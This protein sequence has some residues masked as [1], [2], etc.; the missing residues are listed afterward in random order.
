MTSAPPLAGRDL[1]YRQQAQEYRHLLIE[2]CAQTVLTLGVRVD[3]YDEMLGETDM[4]AL[5]A[6]LGRSPDRRLTT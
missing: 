5:R 3:T 2:L 1:R 6:R 4:A